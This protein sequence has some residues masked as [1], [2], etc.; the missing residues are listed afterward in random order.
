MEKQATDRFKKIILPVVA[1]AAVV[2]I[3]VI[4]TGSKAKPKASTD[5]PVIQFKTISVP[6]PTTDYEDSS[7]GFS[8]DFP[9]TPNIIT[10]T[11]QSPTAGSVPI[12]EYRQ[13]YSSGNEYAYYTVF[14]YNYPASY[15]FPADFLDGA[16]QNFTKVI[17]SSFAGTSVSSKQSTE[18]LG[19]P[20]LAAL[21][22]VPIKLSTTS[23]SKVNTSEELVMTTKNQ[24]LYIISSYG[25]SSNDYSDFINS[26]KFTD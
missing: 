1:L 3:V 9:T 2:L 12:K 14:V 4:A 11:Y 20:A 18:L 22:T 6:K 19:Q 26:F 25:M 7:N 15:Q 8:I 21:I 17:A 16:L 10:S 24:N 5:S 23:T 13:Q